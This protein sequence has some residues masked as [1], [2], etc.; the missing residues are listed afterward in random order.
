MNVYIYATVLLELL[1]VTYISY[2][3]VYIVYY[4]NISYECVYIVYY[5]NICNTHY[6]V[7]I[8]R[9]VIQKVLPVLSTECH[10][11]IMIPFVLPNV[12][13]IAEESSIQEYSTLILPTLRPVFTVQ[14]PVQVR[15]YTRTYVC[16]YICIYVRIYV[17]TYVRM[18]VRMCVCTYVCMYVCMCVCTFVYNKV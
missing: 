2:E 14:N 6:L 16:M 11:N 18:C 4:S 17:C 9:I 15:M 12:L 8:Q 13:L 10:N 1:I 3:C 5:S 7:L